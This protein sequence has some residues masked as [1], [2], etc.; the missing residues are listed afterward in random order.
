M[1]RSARATVR[2]TSRS[3]SPT[4]SRAVRLSGAGCPSVMAVTLP[5]LRSRSAASRAPVQAGGLVGQQS[6]EHGVAV[7]GGA[8]GGL[9]V[10]VHGLVVL[11]VRPA[12]RRREPEPRSTLE[13]AAHLR[14]HLGWHRL[15]VVPLVDDGHLLGSFALVPLHRARRHPQIPGRHAHAYPEGA[16]RRAARTAPSLFST[17]AP[18]PE[19]PAFPG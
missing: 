19:I 15:R 1:A 12:G 7:P 3:T 9:V 10:P 6:L 5:P 2:P 17:S 18:A 14:L 16:T 4:S 8:G 13:L 11:V